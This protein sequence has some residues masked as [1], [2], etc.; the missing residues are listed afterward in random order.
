[1][2]ALGGAR[3]FLLIGT[4]LL[5]LVLIV[6]FVFSVLSLIVRAEFNFDYLMTAEFGSIALIALVFLLVGTFLAKGPYV[7]CLSTAALLVVSLVA[8]MLL[9]DPPIPLAAVVLVLYNL[10]LVLL[11]LH[12]VLSLK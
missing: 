1:M 6:P 7:L 3:A 11:L 10:S 9:S 8:L 12:G 5:A 4:L 2:K